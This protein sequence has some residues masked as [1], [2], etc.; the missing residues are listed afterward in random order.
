MK[1]Q[2]EQQ[3]NAAALEAL[4]VPVLNKLKIKHV[5]KIRTWLN[6]REQVHLPLPDETNAVIDIVLRSTDNEKQPREA[7]R[8]TVDRPSELRDLIVRK[9]FN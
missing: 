5:S 8:R 6:T 7:G 1:G 4:G 2:Y 3:C 9:I